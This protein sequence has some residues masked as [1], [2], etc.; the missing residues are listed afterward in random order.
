MLQPL[1][2]L[3]RTCWLRWRSVLRQHA[4]FSRYW[5]A[6]RTVW[7]QWSRCASTRRLG[8]GAWRLQAVRMPLTH[9][10]MVMTTAIIRSQPQLLHSPMKMT[11]AQRACIVSQLSSMLAS[12][13][14]SQSLTYEG[15]I[16]DFVLQIC[17]HRHLVC[18]TPRQAATS[19]AGV[20]QRSMPRTLGSRLASPPPLCDPPASL[21]CL[22]I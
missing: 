3:S 14:L 21:C 11:R 22:V 10:T 6:M 15:D 16:D 8:A 4:L 19:M 12:M 2:C 20:W 13:L 9:R 18:S 7:L 17:R 5:T 1:A